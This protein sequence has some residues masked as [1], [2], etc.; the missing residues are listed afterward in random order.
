V[1]GGS[2]DALNGVRALLSQAL[3]EARAVDES[4]VAY[5]IEMAIA[6]AN[7][8]GA[9]ARPEL[10]AGGAASPVGACRTVNGSQGARQALG[11][12]RRV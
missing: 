12:A 8:T 2:T 3:V 7:A 6:E 11:V 9:V 1:V 5:F 10:V 4:L